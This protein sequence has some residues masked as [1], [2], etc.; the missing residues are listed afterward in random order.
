MVSRRDF[1]KSTSSGAIAAVMPGASL[2]AATP[3][4]MRAA[5]INASSCIPVQFCGLLPGSET[6]VLNRIHKAPECSPAAACQI[7]FSWATD[8][9]QPWA[10]RS[11][12]VHTRYTPAPHAKT[13]NQN[14]PETPDGFASFERYHSARSA[15]AA[16]IEPYA[17]LINNAKLPTIS[18][19][20]ES[21]TLLDLERHGARAQFTLSDWHDTGESGWVLPLLT[22]HLPL[23]RGNGDAASM[24]LT[25]ETLAGFKTIRQDFLERVT[26]DLQP[27]AP[28][29]NAYARLADPSD[30][31]MVA[32][33]GNPT[34]L[35][36]MLRAG[37]HSAGMG[38]FSVVPLSEFLG[39]DLPALPRVQ[40]FQFGEHVNHPAAQEI[41]SS[42]LT[43]LTTHP[44]DAFHG[45]DSLSC[46]SDSSMQAD[47][48]FDHY[49]QLPH[50]D[51]LTD[52][53]FAAT[54]LTTLTRSLG[55]STATTQVVRNTAAAAFHRWSNFTRAR[56]TAS[57]TA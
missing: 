56:A 40:S 27:M 36:Q 14:T 37:V 15:V 57:G 13:L 49:A 6:T 39:Y 20:N 2:L 7:D 8:R 10:G 18:G 32:I 31:T 44:A 50:L 12:I 5:G 19:L 24:F 55:D 3:A 4:N 1:V 22:Y 34:K 33:Y 28:A 25:P 42:M 54:A 16:A 41:A 9:G 52:G 45:C 29:N 30:K 46:R 53:A 17:V 43:A 51:F 35:T 26:I 11:L 23:F 38:Q 47:Y 48:D 21:R